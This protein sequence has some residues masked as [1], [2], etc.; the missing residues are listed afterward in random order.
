MNQFCY[1]HR[2][3]QIHQKEKVNFLID[4]SGSNLPIYFALKGKHEYEMLGTEQFIEDVKVIVE[5]FA[6]Q[7]DLIVFPESRYPFLRKLTA[8]LKNVV[9]LKKR[10]KEEICEI[11]KAAEGWKKLDLISAEKSWAEMGD[12]FT[13]NKIKSNKRKAYIPYLFEKMEVAQGT[14][15]LLL[16]DFVMSGNT[17]KAME[18]A[19]NIKEYSIM[20]IFYQIGY[21]G[22]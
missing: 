14:K 13:I 12:T 6:S 9:E 16:D 19:L 17:I 5:Q 8:N 22:K 2:E 18:A 21:G 11:V 3:F 7:F 10:N 15:V 4:A 1:L 20:G